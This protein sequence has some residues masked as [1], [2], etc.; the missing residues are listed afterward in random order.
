MQGSLYRDHRYGCECGS[1]SPLCEISSEVFRELHRDECRL[2]RVQVKS[3]KVEVTKRFQMTINL[4]AELLI[5][6]VVIGALYNLFNLSKVPKYE[7]VY[8]TMVLLLGPANYIYFGFGKI[9]FFH[10]IIGF[11]L[12]IR[13]GRNLFKIKNQGKQKT[14]QQLESKHIEASGERSI[15]IGGNVKNSKLV[16]GDKNN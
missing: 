3:D 12:L 16:T 14:D 4:P 15:A 7:M 13:G 8:G 2:R 10:S 9:G 1:C 11:I 6:L 5:E